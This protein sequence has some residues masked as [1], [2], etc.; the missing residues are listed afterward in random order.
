MNVPE[1]RYKVVTAGA[2]TL[3]GRMEAADRPA[4]IDRLHA[5]GHVPLRVDEITRSPLAALFAGALPAR[6]LAPRSLALVTGQLATL[7]R[8]GLALDEALSIIEELI[9]DRF[10]KSCI[11]GLIEKISAGGTIADAMAAQRNAFPQYCVSMVRAGEAGANLDTVLERLADFVER[12][13]ATRAYII[14]A[15][16]YPAIVA[17][18]CLASIAIMLLFVVPRF[19][20]LFEQAGDS[21]PLS[22]KYLMDLSDKL[23]AYWWLEVSI[24]LLGIGLISWHFKKPRTRIA[25]RRRMLKLPLVG[26]LVRKIEVARFSR[27]LGTLMKNGVPL[28]N[29]LAITR[30]TMTNATVAEAVETIMDRAKTGKGLAEPMRETGAFPS[31]AVHLVRIGEES[32]RQD[33]MLVK[34]AEIFETETRRS[35][36][37]LLSLIA[38]AVTIVLGLVV[39]GVFMS[40]MTALLSVYELTL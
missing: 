40:M 35:L 31:L 32:G 29:A 28:L 13:Q 6:R 1:F 26:E 10:E 34:I 38:P 25:W 20:P 8:A 33:E 36:D 22:A 12:S 15:L 27:T 23:S 30:E 14:S 5:L 17:V 4:L 24:L 37:R 11:R 9:E 16:I 2:Q 7:L 21:L 19:R 39:A 18:A 3:E